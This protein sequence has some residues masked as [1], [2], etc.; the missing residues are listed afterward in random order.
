MAWN[1]EPQPTLR[2]ERLILRPFTAD[3]GLRVEELAGAREIADTTAHVPHP[4]PAGGGAGWIATHGPK[5]AAGQSITFAVTTAPD[6]LIGAMGLIVVERVNSATLGYWTGVSYWG[7]GFTTEAARAVVDFGFEVVGLNRVD[8]T[9]LT[10]NPASGR[11]MEKIGMRAE[12]IFREAE[13]KWGVY[14][15]VAQKAILRSE[16]EEARR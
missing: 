8:A 5:W 2:T 16:W 9:Y 6:G 1:D 13:R 15:D 14:E 3:D 7:R 12:G 11:V 4:Y 10:R